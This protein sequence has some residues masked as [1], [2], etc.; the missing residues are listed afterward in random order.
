[1]TRVFIWGFGYAFHIQ[2]SFRWGFL[3]SSDYLCSANTTVSDRFT[4][5]LRQV[6]R[7]WR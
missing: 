6:A 2:V 7:S 3:I 1:M 4:S 5:E